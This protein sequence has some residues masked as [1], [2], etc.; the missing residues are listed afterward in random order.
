MRTVRLPYM[1][2][3]KSE[4]KTIPHGPI[5]PASKLYT[6][7]FFSFIAFGDD[8]ISFHIWQ[9]LTLYLHSNPIL[10]S[11][12]PT[13]VPLVISSPVYLLPS[14]WFTPPMCSGRSG[15]LCTSVLGACRTY[16]P[17][18]GFKGRK[19][20]YAERRASSPF[21]SCSTRASLDTFIRWM[22]MTFRPSYPLCLILVSLSTH[23]P[24]VL[25]FAKPILCDVTSLFTLRNTV[26]KKE[27]KTG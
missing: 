24:L 9:A 1:A 20:S 14:F 2:E 17:L 3:D 10:S 6:N 16:L 27:N 26:F 5:S 22:K 8:E 18:L 21:Q 4:K 11:L 19:Q 13:A 23:N 7:S 12:R 15:C 25:P